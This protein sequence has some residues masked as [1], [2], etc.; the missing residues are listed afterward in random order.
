MLPACAKGLHCKIY[1]KEFF[2]S[3]GVLAYEMGIYL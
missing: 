2:I 3:F 1:L